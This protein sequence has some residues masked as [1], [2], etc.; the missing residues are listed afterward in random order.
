MGLSVFCQLIEQLTFSTRDSF[1]L[2]NEKTASRTH[3]LTS[4]ACGEVEYLVCEMRREP[5][6]HGEEGARRGFQLSTWVVWDDSGQQIS[7]FPVFPESGS[8]VGPDHPYPNVTSSRSGWHRTCMSIKFPSRYGACVGTTLG[9][10]Y[11]HRRTQGEVCEGR[12][13]CWLW[14]GFAT[15]GRDS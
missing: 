9:E 14:V 13:P 10:H 3:S 5:R 4:V 15:R 11:F 7:S 2:G 1:S 12:N 8:P 6:E